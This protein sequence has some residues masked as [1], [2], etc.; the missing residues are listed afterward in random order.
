MTKREKVLIVRVWVTRMRKCVCVFI[1]ICSNRERE[2]ELHSDGVFFEQN[3]IWVVSS[4]AWHCSCS[5]SV[6]GFCSRSGYYI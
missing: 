5:G 1:E 2:I 4:V 6:C 3:N